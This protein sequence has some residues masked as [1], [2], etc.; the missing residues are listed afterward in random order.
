MKRLATLGGLF[1]LACYLVFSPLAAWAAENAKVDPLDWPY[2]RGPEYNGISRETGLPDTWNIEGGEGSNLSWKRDDIHARSTPIVLRGKMYFLARNNPATPIEG[3]KICCLD[4]AT[5]DTI[6]ESTHNVWSSDVPDTRVGWSSVVGDPDTGY[7]Y[8]LGANGLFKCLDGESGKV[9]WSTPLHER[10]GLLST[11]G[12]RTNYPIVCDDLVIVGAVIIGWGDMAMPAF[13]LAGFDKKTGEIAWFESTRLRPEDTTYSGPTLATIRGEKRLF[14]GSGDGWV[15]GFQPRTGKRVWECQLSRRGLNSSPLVDG[16]TVYMSHSEENPA[17]SS[18]MG[19]I[20]AMNGALSGD[21]TKTGILWRIEEE[22]SAGKSALLK[23]GDRLYAADDAGKLFVLDAKTGEQLCRKIPLGTINFA[24]P[25]Y[26]DGK[27]YHVEKNG[28]WYIMTPDEKRGVEAFKRGKTSGMFPS[29]DECWASPVISHGRVYIITT[30]AVYCFEDKTK[31]HG[32]TP[33][34]EPAKETPVSDDPKPALVQ[35]FPNEVLMKPGETQAFTVRLFN[36]NGQFLKESTAEFSYENLGK[37]LAKGSFNKEGAF[38]ADPASTHSAVKVIAKV[39]DLV[40][41]ARVRIVPPLPWKFDFE[42]LKDAPITWVGA[43]YRHRI[44]NVDGSAAMVKST[45]IPKGTRSRAS[46]GPSDL[47]DYTIQADMKMAGG[48]TKAPD[49]GLIAQG[50]TFEYQ[51]EGQNLLIHSWVSHDKRSFKKLHPFNLKTGTWYTL[52]LKA[53]NE[54]ST[55]KVQAKIWPRDEKEPEQW[56]IELTDLAPNT[57]GAP[58]MFGN[59]TN[60]EIYIDNVIVT[61]NDK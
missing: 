59:A 41:H 56:T 4:A 12:G 40:G 60:A 20:A 30:G 9:I 14:I 44:D 17:P 58:G 10:L 21:I 34:P 48:D 52:K 54:G 8:A 13:R 33:R 37:N 45:T 47:S 26:A 22:V 57:H 5:G 36:S 19:A 61:P 25:V 23:V 38:T 35:V 11:Y 2:W 24:S 29:G 6:W 51:G 18:K 53:A 39:G 28:R 42:G 15:Y 43:R 31:K 46:F 55:A 7:V 1:V 50:Y 27:I 3:E 16:E 32:S 49:I